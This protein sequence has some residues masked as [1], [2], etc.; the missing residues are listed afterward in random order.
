MAPVSRPGMG[1]VS[2]VTIPRSTSEAEIPGPLAGPL[3]TELSTT[4]PGMAPAGVPAP[5]V[6]PVAAVPPVPPAGP[7]PVADGPPVDAPAAVAPCAAA[8]AV[9]PGIEPPV[10]A[11][12][13]PLPVVL[14]AAS[15]AG[16]SRAPQAEVSSATPATTARARQPRAR[17]PQLLAARH[18]AFA[19]MSIAVLLG[20]KRVPPCRRGTPAA[21]QVRIAFSKGY[22]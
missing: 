16:L 18:V 17:R 2:V 9:C 22:T 14:S 21:L 20:P 12:P 7:A 10:L 15:W 19:L 6:P 5:P 3:H 4:V 11:D 1:P 8:V 13:L